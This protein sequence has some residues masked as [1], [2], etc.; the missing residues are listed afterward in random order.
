M[1]TSASQRHQGRLMF[2]DY[3]LG[4]GLG[5]TEHRVIVLNAARSRCMTGWCRTP[6][7]ATAFAARLTALTTVTQPRPAPG[8]AA[9]LSSLWARLSRLA[10][11]QTIDRF[12]IASPPAPKRRRDATCWP[13]QVTDR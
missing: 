2:D 3:D 7:W 12:P 10:I 11:N 6:V 9:R 1:P 8:A 13:R 5:D 4:R